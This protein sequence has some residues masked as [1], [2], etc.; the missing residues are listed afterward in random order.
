MKIEI[1]PLSVNEAW[2]GRR[3]KTDKYKQ[4]EKYL[5]LL[6]PK[7]DIKKKEKLKVD[8]VFGFA[9]KASD[10][11]NPV[12]PC[13]DVLQKKYG[14]NDNDIFEM[15]IKKEVVGK[16]NEFIELNIEQI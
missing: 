16:G 15:N 7:L 5:M 14:I 3:F 1:K 6:L 9:T 11:D 4:F 8:F 12:K 2:Q 13:L 10:I